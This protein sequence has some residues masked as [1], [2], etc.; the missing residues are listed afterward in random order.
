MKNSKSWYLIQYDI[1]NKRRLAKV[2]KFL[3]SIAI[4][5]QN[6]VFAWF[7]SSKELDHLQQNL[8]KI[9]NIYEDDIRGYLIT[10]P[11]VLYGQSPFIEEVYFDN[12]PPHEIKTL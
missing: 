3:C 9:I 8:K 6:S 11:I 12:Y 10:Q 2:H 1:A 4:P 7:G 5:L